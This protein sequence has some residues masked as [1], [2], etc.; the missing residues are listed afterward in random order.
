[1][2]KDVVVV[3]GRRSTEMSS[4]I[5][6]ARIYTFAYIYMCVLSCDSKFRVV[7][8]PLHAFVINIMNEPN[9]FLR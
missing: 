9:K 7:V 1:M 4:Y 3:I 5:L 2:V 6:S 8:S